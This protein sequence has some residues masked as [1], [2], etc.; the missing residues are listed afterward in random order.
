MAN[1]NLPAPKRALV[2]SVSKPSQSSTPTIPVTLK[3]T[4][5]VRSITR[6]YARHP[7][8][9]ELGGG[10]IPGLK[11]NRKHL[12]A[13]IGAICVVVGFFFLAKEGSRKLFK[14]KDNSGQNS[15]DPPQ[16]PD[17]PKV[18]SV[19]NCVNNAGNPKAPLIPDMVYEGG[20]SLLAGRTNAGK[21]LLSQQMAI[22][23]S[24]GYGELVG[25]DIQPQN[26]IIV[27]GEMDDDDYK[28]RF[29]G[30]D[31]E[32]PANITRISDCDFST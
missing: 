7:D 31:M 13:A 21:T 6:T 1:T 3:T 5:R 17:P 11:C 2:G 32:I 27:D 22:E 4:K 26:V 23:I 16:V 14:D 12:G 18:E 9:I 28:R 8:L 25:E 29:G 19:V 30:E 24:R 10:L 20:I 15:N